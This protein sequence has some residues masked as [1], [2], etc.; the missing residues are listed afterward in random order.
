MTGNGEVFPPSF[1]T[2]DARIFYTVVSVTIADRVTI[3]ID[4]SEN[5]V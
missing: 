1:A 3:Y 5:D 4:I 2:R